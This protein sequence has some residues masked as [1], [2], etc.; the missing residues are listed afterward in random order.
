MVGFT[1]LFQMFG[2]RPL[3]VV[4]P[5]DGFEIEVVQKDQKLLP[6]LLARARKVNYLTR[7]AGVHASFSVPKSTQWNDDCLGIARGNTNYGRRMLYQ[8]LK[9]LLAFGF[10]T[11]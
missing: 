3:N 9:I 11:R 8:E 2:T 4:E 1:L 7:I 6:L 10:C 5:A